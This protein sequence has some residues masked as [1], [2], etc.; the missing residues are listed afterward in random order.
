MS[1]LK[2]NIDSLAKFSANLRRLPRVL[3]EQVAEQAAPVLTALVEATFKASEDAY[4][5]SW[6]PGKEGQ[7]VTLRK[8]GDLAKGLKY[9]AI[10]T[11]L[12][13]RLAVAHAKYQ[14][15][16]R[17]VAPRQGSPLPVEYSQAL[18]RIVAAVCRKELAR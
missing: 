9:I 10:G 18:A 15:G 6:A 3:G 12:R 5:N 2:G 1:G 13:L 4:G 17:P 11:K 16:K 7:K 14:L 8:K